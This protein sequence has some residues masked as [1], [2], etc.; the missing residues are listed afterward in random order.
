MSVSSQALTELTGLTVPDNV[1]A[2]GG[3]CYQI[4]LFGILC[5]L[6]ASADIT[7]ASEVKRNSLLA[8]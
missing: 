6:Y 7:R 1:L 3:G 8:S 5:P 4:W 2:Q